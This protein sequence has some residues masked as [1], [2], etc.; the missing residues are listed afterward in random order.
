M[1]ASTA[2][3]SACRSM[4]S[5]SGYDAAASISSSS[6]YSCIEEYHRLWKDVTCTDTMENTDGSTIDWEYAD[7]S[8]LVQ[9]TLEN[10]EELQQVWAK[11]ISEHPG[12]LSQPW[13]VVV[14][15]DEYS[16]GSQLRAD[17]SKKVMNLMFNFE[18]LGSFALS[19]ACT[20]FVAVS[21]RTST[22]AKIKGG[23][24]KMLAH[25]LKKMLLSNTGFTRSGLPVTLNGQPHLIWSKL[26]AIISD[27]D[28]LRLGA[29]W[30]GAA[31]IRPCLRHG[32]VFSRNSDLASRIPGAVE[33]TCCQ[34][35][36]FHRTTSAEFYASAD[37][38]EAATKGHSQGA[39]SK[40]LCDLTCK[41]ESLNFVEGGLIFE[42]SLRHPAVD[43][44]RAL[45]FDW[46]HS[47]LQ[48]G[49]FSKEAHLLISHAG[50]YGEVEEFFKRSWRFA[51]CRQSEGKQLHRI[52]SDW[53]R[54]AEGNMEKLK[55]SMSEVLSMYALLRH[56]ASM[57]PKTE[58][59]ELQ[60]L[61]FFR[62]C[63]VVDL[64]LQTKRQILKA[65]R[66]SSILR[67]AIEEWMS[68]HISAYGVQNITPKFHWL[69]DVCDQL[70]TNGILLDQLVVERLHLVVKLHGSTGR[71]FERQ[72]FINLK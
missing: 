45:H 24:T 57:L 54:D 33:I 72:V 25:F 1:S 62:G 35:S 40:K 21:V 32:N 64:F 39:L 59:N 56:W 68:A 60:L 65:E 7:P 66:A 50:T 52:F 70:E 47:A 4:M 43:V 27:G 16:P 49:A 36:L 18:E 58:D 10:S 15:Y 44:F 48:D 26:H 20:W 11:A 29:S 13:K 55:A 5:H 17:N 9:T 2:S 51:R 3:S 61:S 23:W 46:A 19:Q 37:K 69:Y 63:R 41:A 8:R 38:V 67:K 14:A 42:E 12:S 31:S 6:R 22:I 34:S 28:G 53:R 71:L 30:R